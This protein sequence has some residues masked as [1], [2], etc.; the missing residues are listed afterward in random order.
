MSRAA[1]QDAQNTYNAQSKA[2]QLY[3][4]NAAATYSQ[5]MR[6]YTSMALNPRV[7]IRPK[8]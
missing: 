8:G 3:G 2:S 5:L 7:L 1:Q 4:A 6:Q